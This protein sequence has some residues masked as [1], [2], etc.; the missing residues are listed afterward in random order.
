MKHYAVN[1]KS[2]SKQLQDDGKLLK[3]PNPV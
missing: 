2:K 3:Q 1:D